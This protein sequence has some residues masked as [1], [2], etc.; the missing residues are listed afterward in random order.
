MLEYF[1]MFKK[2]QIIFCFL[3]LGCLQT[4]KAIEY[5]INP[6]HSNINF[7]V[8]H[9]GKGQVK[10]QFRLFSGSLDYEPNNLKNAKI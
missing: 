9:F 5:K 8:A 4:A 10:G 2:L 1:L 3:F 7:M 6:T